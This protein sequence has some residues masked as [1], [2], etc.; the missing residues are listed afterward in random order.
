VWD[1][2]FAKKE[3]PRQK[4][5]QLDLIIKSSKNITGINAFIAELD[6]SVIQ[7]KIDQKKWAKFPNIVQELE[8][9]RLEKEQKGP[10]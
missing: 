2:L 8:Q 5:N 7:N 4:V 9:L 1:Q 3:L 10:E 6:Q